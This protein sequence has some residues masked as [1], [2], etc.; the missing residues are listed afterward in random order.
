MSVKKYLIEQLAAHPSMCPQDAA[1]LCYQAAYG[2]EH[3][4]ADAAAARDYFMQEYENTPALDLPLYENISDDYARINIAPWK[5]RS[6]DPQWL[7]AL[8][9]AGSEHK[10][11]TVALEENLRCVADNISRFSF[12]AQNWE[13]FIN[14]YRAQGMPALHHSESYRAAEKPAYRLV[15]RDVLRVLPV[16][17]AASKYD[18]APCI[19]AIDGRAGSGK[20]TMAALLSRVLGGEVVHMDDFFLPPVLRTTERLSQPGGNVHYERFAKEV[21]PWLRSGENFDYTVFSCRIMD[22]D[23]TREI[24][25]SKYIIVE[26]SYSLHPCFGDYADISVFSDIDPEEQLRRLRLRNGDAMAEIFKN[27]WIPMEEMYFEACKLRQS[28]GLVI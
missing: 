3:L 9:C 11:S 12:T 19:I 13:A 24:R 25:N 22:F 26:G 16:L 5:Y 20:S 21:L 27:K 28:C 7:F 6:L 18:K 1:K 10:G 23:G 14:D 4:L 8:F 2:M 15:R 17:E